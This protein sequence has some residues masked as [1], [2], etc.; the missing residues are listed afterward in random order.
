MTQL[1]GNW[2]EDA[3][4]LLTTRSEDLHSSKQNDPLIHVEDPTVL[5]AAKIHAANA[6]DLDQ[7]VG[8]IQFDVEE[9][10]TYTRAMQGPNATEWAKAM[11]EELDQLQKNNIWV[12]VPRSEIE[13]GHR[14]L[15]GK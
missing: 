13:P 15:G 9:L 14:P 7:F 2:E 1:L 12:L 8:S 6:D 10:E 4:V 5:L 3:R 11:E